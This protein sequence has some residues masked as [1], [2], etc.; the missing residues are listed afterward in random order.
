[1]QKFFALLLALVSFSA[2]ADE[3]CEIKLSAN[4]IKWHASRYEAKKFCESYTQV[5]CKVVNPSLGR[6]GSEIKFSEVF[7]GLSDQDDFKAARTDA[8]G[9]YFQSL[10]NKQLYRIPVLFTLSFDCKN[11]Y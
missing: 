10:E 11:K 4:E 7:V 3:K 2:Y 6:W 1:M 9:L 8:Y 5:S